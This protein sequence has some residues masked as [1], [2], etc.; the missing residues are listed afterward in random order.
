MTPNFDPTSPNQGT[1]LFRPARHV[2]VWPEGSSLT[3]LDLDRGLCHATTPAGADSWNMLVG[4]QKARRGNGPAVPKTT[5]EENS[6]SWVRVA[7]Y[8]L[9]QR[10]IE[11]AI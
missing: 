4:T 1:G 10:I 5:E 9:D 11:P 3:I 8:L 7:A 6:H 2:V